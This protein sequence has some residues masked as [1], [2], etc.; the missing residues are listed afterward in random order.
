MAT[1]EGVVCVA[2]SQVQVF[3][4][5]KTRAQ[6]L[7][8]RFE[9][10][11]SWRQQWDTKA[12]DW[13]KLY[14]GYRAPLKAGETR[15]NL[16]IPRTYEEIDT[17]RSRMHKSFFATKPY[18]DFIS[19]P[20][21][22][23][24]FEQW[25]SN[26][27]KADLAGA[28]VCDDLEKNKIELLFYNFLTQLLTMPAAIL[29]VGW[30]FETANVKR[31]VP[32]IVGYTPSPYG[33]VPEIGLV[34]QESE[35]VVWDGNELNLVD[36]FDFYPDPMGIDIDKARFVFQREWA[37]QDVIEQ[38]LELL[39]QAGT[40]NVFWPDFTKLPAATEYM[41]EG[42]AERMSAVGVDL[43]TNDP[44]N[45]NKADANQDLHEVLHYWEDGVYAILINRTWLAFEGDNPYWRHGKKP[46]VVASWEPLPNE[47]YGMSAVQIVRYLQ[48]EVNTQHNQ[49]IDNVSMVINRMWKVRKG[50]DI[51]DSE[52]VS[53]P[54][55]IIRVDNMD[56][57]VELIMKDV[58]ASAYNEESLTRLDME[59]ALG[60]PDVVRGV[61]GDKDQTATEVVTKSTSA[62]IR[63][64]TK[65]MLFEVLGM[66]RL[67]ELLDM[68][69]Q[70][71]I[72]TPRL[73]R[74]HGQEDVMEW[75]TVD[76]GQI[77]G[78]Y[79]YRPAGSNVDP[80]ANKEM[81]RQQLNEVM[82]TIFKVQ[83]PWIDQYE[84]FK[85]WLESFDIRHVEKVMFTREEVIQM[86]QQQLQQQ[87]Q[88]QQQLG[89]PPAPQGFGGG[90]QG[91]SPLRAPSPAPMGLSARSA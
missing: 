61:S 43:D 20:S 18:V 2:Q 69:N 46:F 52:L 42:R 82:Q 1:H 37:T 91:M 30:R 22:P 90:G 55:G 12:I 31:R 27:G 28:V 4:D 81:R 38:R 36:H 68:N 17:L 29:S 89:G 85:M 6:E 79:D 51:P 15:S 50:A 64:D 63:F 83:P 62:G 77:I 14:V 72:D 23:D 65:I 39:E 24:T 9:Y 53:R 71:W 5:P 8:R 47:F 48:D 41:S 40:G 45:A 76:P 32:G 58:A 44:F 86:M 57:V 34:M 3:R 21:D 88:H 7:F 25:K 19:R 66:T 74:Q 80:A 73:V 16:H 70:Q 26:A 67:C 56:D 78:E 13:Y 59:S 75:M 35:E 10:S 11:R 33:Y 84:L 49:R 60:V 54:H 87:Q